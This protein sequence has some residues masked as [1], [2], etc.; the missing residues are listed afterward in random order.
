MEAQQQQ[1]QQQER[2]LV[3]RAIR[4]DAEAFQAL[5]GRYYRPVAAF[6]LRRLAGRSDVVEDLTQETFLEAFRSLR[7]GARPEVFS[8]WLFGIAANRAGKWLRRKKPVL[9]D[10][11][12]PP[13]MPTAPSDADTH[14]EMEEQRHRLAALD[15]GLAGL[16]DDLRDL[17]EMKHRRGLTCEQIA[18]QTGR[19]VGTIKSLLSRTYKLLRQRLAPPGDDS[20]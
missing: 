18:A 2:Q 19:P 15:A 20:P 7:D 1:Q 3:E 6:L 8:S 11:G 4:G 10:P 13:S 5:A 9:F 17:L 14:A 12:A 16:P